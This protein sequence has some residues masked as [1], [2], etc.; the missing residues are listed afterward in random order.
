MDFK[1]MFI[2]AV[3]LTLISFLIKDGWVIIIGVWLT[4][5][6]MCY[7]YCVYVIKKSRKNLENAKKA[8]LEGNDSMSAAIMNGCNDEELHQIFTERDK[9]DAL[10]IYGTVDEQKQKG[11][12]FLTNSMIKPMPQDIIDR[13]LTDNKYWIIESHKGKWCST[14]FDEYRISRFDIEKDFGEYFTD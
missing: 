4:Y 10:R 6:L 5:A 11:I 13:I 8:F 14:E 3:S 2:T 7:L 12:R 9:L 1:S